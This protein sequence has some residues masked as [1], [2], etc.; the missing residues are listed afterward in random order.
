LKN[1]EGHV[2]VYNFVVNFQQNQILFGNQM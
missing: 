1:D 2:K